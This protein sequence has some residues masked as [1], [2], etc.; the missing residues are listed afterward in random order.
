[1]FKKI[2]LIIYVG[3]LKKNYI[4]RLNQVSTK[5]R[6]SSTNRCSCWG[7]CSGNRDRARIFFERWHH[8]EIFF[9]ICWL[10]SKD[11]LRFLC[12]FQW[13]FDLC[14]VEWKEFFRFFNWFW[15]KTVVSWLISK[16]FFRF[17]VDFQRTFRFFVSFR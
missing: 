9:L 1:M 11:F 16:E 6:L 15:E 4:C 10:I 14:F 2:K 12:W 5:R 7:V 13:I 8:I 3:S 17:L